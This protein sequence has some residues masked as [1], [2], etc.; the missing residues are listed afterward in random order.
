MCG[1]DLLTNKPSVFIYGSDGDEEYEIEAIK[2][3]FDLI[4]KFA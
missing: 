1:V 3:W 4:D 2:R